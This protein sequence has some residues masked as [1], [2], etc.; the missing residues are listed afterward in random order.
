[1][2]ERQT[3]IAEVPSNLDRSSSEAVSKIVRPGISSD[4]LAL[5]GV[6][7]SDFPEPRSID[8]PYFDVDGQPIEFSRWRLPTIRSNGQKYHQMPGSGVHVYFPPGGINESPQLVIVEG[9]FKALS[10]FELGMQVIGLCGLYTYRSDKD[11]KKNLLVEIEHALA[12][13][14]A[15]KVFFIGDADTATNLN[16]ARSAQFLTDQIAPIPVSL[17]RLPLGGP[18]GFD[19]WKESWNGASTIEAGMHVENFFAGAPPVKPGL[20]FV[21]LAEILLEI[22]R[23]QFKKLG[24]GEHQNQIRKLVRMA[25]EARISDEPA[26]AIGRLGRLAAKVSG[27][28][29]K[30][31]NRSVEQYLA[32]DGERKS[33]SRPVGKSRER[34]VNVDGDSARPPLIKVEV[35]KPLLTLPC[36]EVEIIEAAN[37]L[38]TRLKATFRYYVRDRSVFEVIP[39][40][41]G[42]GLRECA[43][44]S[45]RSQIEDYFNLGKIVKTGHGKPAWSKCR[46]SVDSAKALL[47]ADAAWQILPPVKIVTSSPIFVEVD[48]ELRV[49]NKGYH[50]ELGGILVTKERNIREVDLEE[51]WHSLLG[52]LEDFDFVAES[53]R[54]RA[55]ASFISPAL[56]LGGLLKCDFPL[57]FAE[58]NESQSGKTY[59]QKV[60]CAIYG[61]TPYVINVNEERGVGTLDEKVSDALLSGRPF[62]M[63]ENV[64]G[65]LKSQLL[66]SA[67]RGVG[68]VQARRAYSRSVQVQ[69]DQL[70]WFL[71]SNRV[72]S[73]PDLANRSIITRM[74]KQPTGFLFKGYPEGNL[75]GHVSAK[76]DYYLSCVFAVVRFWY[77]HGMPRTEDTR[78]DFREW[79]QTLD[80][81]VQQ[82]F[83]LPPLLDDHQCEQQRIANPG[84]SWLREVAA[85]VDK[86]KRLEEGLRA[87]D[88]IEVCEATGVQI[89]GC[90][91]VTPPD[92]IPMVIG[93]ILKPIFSSALTVE[94]G[95][96]RVRRE[97]RDEYD[98]ENRMNRPVHYHFFTRGEECSP[99]N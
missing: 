48:R 11:G 89:P 57:D 94:V 62:L 93:K 65:V 19:D 49:L 13:S 84:L 2:E 71:S 79:C 66:E 7:L 25:A 75:I 96:Y 45:F 92:R 15:E 9:E 74:R 69:T 95:G 43:P 64:R 44:D 70:C 98:P 38:F 30:E 81:I 50:S 80:W 91:E 58:A 20:S 3:S 76:A 82:V 77:R 28:G 87:N 32:D 21:A 14:R 8:I 54:S 88:V 67:I 55:I 42:A 72:T 17:P 99:C 41:N 36:N 37:R 27:S 26:V 33:A 5:A 6:R 83:N 29:W 34:P 16:F 86:L 85:S 90:Y 18:K 73:T 61:E 63:L 31:F 12:H 56:R 59:R 47:S 22:T 51:A 1:M 39:Q 4:T 40:S 78:H 24:P 52:L 23:P 68:I 10:I 53:D 35:E 97:T 46:C 60:A